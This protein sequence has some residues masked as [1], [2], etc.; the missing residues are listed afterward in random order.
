MPNQ[1]FPRATRK[2]LS[3]SHT[4]DVLILTVFSLPDSSISISSAS[5]KKKKKN[6]SGSKKRLLLS[7]PFHLRIRQCSI[8]SREAHAYPE[9]LKKT[10]RGTHVSRITQAVCVS[11]PKRVAMVFVWALAPVSTLAVLE[12]SA[13]GRRRA[14]RSWTAATQPHPTMGCR[15]G[16]QGALYGI[17]ATNV[18]TQ[19]PTCIGNGMDPSGTQ[20]QKKKKK[21]KATGPFPT[22]ENHRSVLP[23]AKRM[24]WCYLFTASVSAVSLPNKAKFCYRMIRLMSHSGQL[25]HERERERY[26][27]SSESLSCS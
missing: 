24:Q 26:V 8:H 10:C 18:R 15:R 25:K 20:Q 1:K 2:V 6:C 27:Q 17:P 5:K 11:T 21:Q 22:A 16:R 3:D 23:L 14:R 4:R 7:P 9:F 19:E 13:F 12:C